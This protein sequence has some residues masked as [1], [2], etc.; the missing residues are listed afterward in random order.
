MKF[1]EAK[2]S[3]N[4]SGDPEP[5]S[6]PRAPSCLQRATSKFQAFNES[7]ELQRASEFDLQDSGP[8]NLGYQQG[9][10]QGPNVQ[11]NFLH[12]YSASDTSNVFSAV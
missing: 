2:F 8:V 9:S 4:A 7:N 3:S 5:I 6:N 11:G 10:D 12:E 1:H